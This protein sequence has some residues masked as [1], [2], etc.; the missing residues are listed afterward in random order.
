MQNYSLNNMEQT[1]CKRCGLCCQKGGPALH[2]RDLALVRSGRL[3]KASLITIR[4]GE[5]AHNPRSGT[6]EPLPAELVKIRGRGQEWECCYYQPTGHGCA[7]YRDRPLACGVLK[8]W[9]PREILALVGQDL[10]SRLDILNDEDPL[11]P[12]VLEHERLCPCPDLAAVEKELAV[13]TAGVLPALETAVR[14][15]LAFRERVITEFKLQLSA[16]LF[17]FG[18]PL[19]QLLQPFGILLSESAQG[20]RLTRSKNCL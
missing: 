7:I 1:E 5:L 4:R 6:I 20:L 17:L 18:R 19:F 16:E 15:D 3:P 12:L 8:C 11:R 10:L 13:R 9:Q 14:I 2:G